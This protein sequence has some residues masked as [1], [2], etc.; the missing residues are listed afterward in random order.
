MKLYSDFAAQRA[1]QITA[2]A[3]ALVVIALSVAAG[4]AVSSVVGQLAQ[5][6]DQMQNAG[7][8]FR[9][10]MT[11]VGDRLGSVPLI[12]SGISA[13]FDTASAAGD[14]L[15]GAGE[16]LSDLVPQ[17]A[18]ALGFGVAALPILLVLLVWLLPSLRFVLRKS[19]T[20]ALVRAGLD[21]DLLA[22]RALTNQ[23]VAA[24][25]AI[26]PDALGAWRRHDPEITRRLGALELRS[27]GIRM[28]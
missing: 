25:A 12:G 10:S 14:T 9:T 16:R 27:V 1:L 23:K 20:Q 15:A 4:V 11:D 28:P 8:D 24:I 3:I 26:G 22:L 18:F 2:D 5:L 13:P 21:P 19:R 7:A 17:A 6:A